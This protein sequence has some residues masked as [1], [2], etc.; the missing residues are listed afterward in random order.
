MCISVLREDGPSRAE[1]CRTVTVNDVVL[2]CISALVGILRIIVTSLHGCEQ[3]KHV[4][5]FETCKLASRTINF[6]RQ[7]CSVAPHPVSLHQ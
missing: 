5:E 1:T 3:D 7:L 4:S 2:I 6:A